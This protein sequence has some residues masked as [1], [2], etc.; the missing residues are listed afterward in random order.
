MTLAE[1][2]EQFQKFDKTLKVLR[3]D[4]SGGYEE[5]FEITAD[6]AIDNFTKEKHIAIIL[7]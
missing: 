6:E 3:Y 1:L 4:N 5:I 2:I 7:K